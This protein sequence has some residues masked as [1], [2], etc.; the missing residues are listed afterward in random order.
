[1][2]GMYAILSA[3]PPRAIG[4]TFIGG[5]SL[6]QCSFELLTFWSPLSNTLTPNMRCGVILNGPQ[7]LLHRKR[8]RS[9]HLAPIS[10]RAHQAPPHFV[11]TSLRSSEAPTDIERPMP[12]TKTKTMA[13]RCSDSYPPTPVDHTNDDECLSF[14]RKTRRAGLMHA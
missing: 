10:N 8:A 12:K 5:K 14:A 9:C 1:M 4:K 6:R 3:T 13:G 7:N 2:R 11:R